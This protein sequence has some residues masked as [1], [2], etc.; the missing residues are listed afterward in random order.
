LNLNSKELITKLK[1]KG[2]TSLD[3]TIGVLSMVGG[4]F[5]SVG[6]IATMLVGIFNKGK[7][8]SY[9]IQNLFLARNMVHLANDKNSAENTKDL[10]DE[11]VVAAHS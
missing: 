8:T 3:I 9:V 11:K 4:L 10:N 6:A 1:Q 5:T 7:F 2:D